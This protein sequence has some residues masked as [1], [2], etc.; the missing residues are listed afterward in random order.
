LL[1]LLR[2]RRAGQLIEKT[3]NHLVIVLEDFDGV[4]P[5]RR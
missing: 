1:A 3:L 4:V 2:L 5:A